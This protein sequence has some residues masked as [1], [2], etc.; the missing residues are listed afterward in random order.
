MSVTKTYS[1]SAEFVGELW[2]WNISKGMKQ[3]YLQ[4]FETPITVD[5]S[6][7]Q[8]DAQIKALDDAA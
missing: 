8:I 3:R 2:F 1:S 7:A 4:Q 5:F 6:H